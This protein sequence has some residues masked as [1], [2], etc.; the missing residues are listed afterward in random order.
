MNAL[1]LGWSQ[2]ADIDTPAGVDSPGVYLVRVAHGGKAM[3][4]Q[5]F[6][7]FD[8][9]GV[10]NIGCTTSIEQR[11]RQFVAGRDTCNGHSCA[12]LLWYMRSYCRTSSLERGLRLQFVFAAAATKTAAEETENRLIKSYYKRHGEVPP[13]N[14]AI[15]DRYDERGAVWSSVPEWPELLPSEWWQ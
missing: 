2:W 10:I 11:R 9:L 8:P 12:N 5:R 1:G 7:N 6:L 13:L 15:P 3:P 14:S 4:V